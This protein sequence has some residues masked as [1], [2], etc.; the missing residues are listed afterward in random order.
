MLLGYHLIKIKLHVRPT[1]PILCLEIEYPPLLLDLSM[2]DH[3]YLAAEALG[4]PPPPRPP[5]G[6]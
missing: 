4:L 2:S 6:F 3:P 1:K 5:F